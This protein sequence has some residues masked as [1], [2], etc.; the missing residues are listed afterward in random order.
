MMMILV[1]IEKAD[2][3]VALYSMATANGARGG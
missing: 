3:K 2:Q 1:E